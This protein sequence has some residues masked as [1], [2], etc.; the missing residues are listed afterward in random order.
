MTTM[1]TFIVTLLLLPAIV[2]AC[3]TWLA[4]RDV[5]AELEEFDSF[6]GMH[7]NG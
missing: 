4:I 6:D 3:V 2:T 5:E 7:F 1:H